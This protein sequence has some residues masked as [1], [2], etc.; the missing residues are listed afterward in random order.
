VTDSSAGIVLSA[1]FEGALNNL[2]M[3]DVMSNTVQNNEAAGINVIGGWS[4]A[5]NTIDTL[6]KDNTVSDTGIGV[7]VCAGTSTERQDNQGAATDNQA[8]TQ[9]L[10]N[11]VERSADTGIVVVG[12]FDDSRGAVIGNTV[13]SDIIDN[14]A[15]GIVCADNIDGNPANCTIQG[16]TTQ[17]ASSSNSARSIAI[18]Q[19][20]S[21]Q[22]HLADKAQQLRKRAAGLADQ[23]L[24]AQLLQL[25]NRLERL[26]EKLATR[27]AR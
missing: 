11:T 2:L 6:I 20:A 9:I 21:R 27:A 10:N 3:A 12:G 23:R 16:N 15:D 5:L 25:G 7:F 4:A 26:Q 19:L 14:Q 24:R 8:L 13:E 22:A 1:G 18:E 17:S